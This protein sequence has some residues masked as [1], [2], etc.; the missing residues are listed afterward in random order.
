MLYIDL[1]KL[2]KEDSQSKYIIII[3]NCSQHIF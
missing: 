1:L 2:E 3:T